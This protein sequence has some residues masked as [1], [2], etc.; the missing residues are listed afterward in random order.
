M[1]SVRR[2]G[3]R[4]TD[5]GR[6]EVDVAVRRGDFQ[7]DVAISVAPGEVLGVLGPN[8]AGKTTLL[9]VLAGLAAVD[10]GQHPARCHRP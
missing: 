2:A 9:R 4:A 5:V 10:R 3:G 7:L 1:T 8:G 6:L